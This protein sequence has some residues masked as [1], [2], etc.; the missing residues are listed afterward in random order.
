MSQV[1]ISGNASGTGTLTIAAPNTN[2]NYTLNLPA[3]TGTVM[4]SGNM[5]AFSVYLSANQSISSSTA[6]KIALNT[7]EFDT[8]NCFDSTTN[9]RFTPNVAGYYQ[10]NGLCVNSGTSIT[11]NWFRIYKNGSAYSNGNGGGVSTGY[12]MISDL[13]Y[14]N[15]TT[16]YVEFYGFITA[17]SPLFA[18][19]TAPTLTKVSGVLVR[20]A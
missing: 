3:A 17:T 1:A 5:P 7:E 15:G 19:S 16:D 4:V 14:L 18:G 10:F 9:Y 6:T 8:A 2:S 13:V 11:N 12:L 20:S